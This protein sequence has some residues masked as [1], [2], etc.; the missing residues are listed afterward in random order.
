MWAMFNVTLMGSRGST[1]GPTLLWGTNEHFMG[2]GWNV[3]L[4]GVATDNVLALV[5]NPS[6][7]MRQEILFKLGESH[8]KKRA[9]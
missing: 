2:I 3:V 7:R 8:T 4:S 6:P 5:K 9:Y 1:W